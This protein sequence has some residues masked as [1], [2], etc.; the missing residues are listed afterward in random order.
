[1]KVY[2]SYDFQDRKVVYHLIVSPG[3]LRFI[4]QGLCFLADNTYKNS[5]R[6]EDAINEIK[7]ALKSE[8]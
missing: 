5:S 2:K 1:M 4:L 6:L 3:I 7:Y 8:K